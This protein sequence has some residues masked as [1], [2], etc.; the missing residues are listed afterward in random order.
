MTFGPIQAAVRS[1]WQKNRPLK[2]LDGVVILEFDMIRG[3]H[4]GAPTRPPSMSII[5]YPPGRIR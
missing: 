5:V 4:V 3:I 2:G 1:I